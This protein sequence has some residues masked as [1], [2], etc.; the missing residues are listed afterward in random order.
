[1]FRRAAVVFETEVAEAHRF[2]IVNGER[3]EKERQL[4]GNLAPLQVHHVFRRRVRLQQQAVDVAAEALQAVRKAV[5][6]VRRYAPR[7]AG[8]FE[9]ERR[10]LRE[11]RVGGERGQQVAAAERI[12]DV[13]RKIFRLKRRQKRR[14]DVAIL[15][16]RVEFRLKRLAMRVHG[17][18]QLIRYRLVVGAGDDAEELARFAIE[19][20]A[21]GRL[22][23][24][25]LGRRDG[26]GKING[27]LW[28]LAAVDGGLR[29]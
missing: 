29:P 13:A 1:M 28:T 19:R 24:R 17:G 6:V 21:H 9:R 18:R 16:V 3:D 10:Y 26:R 14:R 11:V 20:L 23:L 15:P 25:H 7:I 12:D 5:C 2:L 4:P 8:V 27:W 22:E